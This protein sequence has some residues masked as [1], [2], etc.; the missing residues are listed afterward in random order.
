MSRIAGLLRRTFGVVRE[1]V[2]TD[3]LGNKYYFV[4]EQKTWTGRRIRAKR[5]VVAVNPKEYDYVEG[6]IP[7]EW[8]AWIRGRRKEPPSV[9]ELLRNAHYK[10]QIKLKAR[11]VEERDLALQAKEHEEGLVATPLRTM[12]KGHAAA[13]N[14]GQQQISEDPTSTANTFQ[15]GSWISNSKK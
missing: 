7:S 10:E 11:E 15:P 6:S 5:M 9:E 3:H 13:A 1:H 8:D 12:S 14:Y 4:P 2:G